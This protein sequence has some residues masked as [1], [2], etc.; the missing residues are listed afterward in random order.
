MCLLVQA[1]ICQ[2]VVWVLEAGVFTVILRSSLR[3]GAVVVLGSCIV[4]FGLAV[5]GT[6]FCV[7]WVRAVRRVHVA[8]PRRLMKLQRMVQ[9]A[10]SLNPVQVVTVL[11][12]VTALQVCVAVCI[13]DDVGDVFRAGNIPGAVA[14]P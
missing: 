14:N 9:F 1:I 11:H 7:V 8:L 5:F 4:H 13:G 3:R 2:L 10:A 12:G 6:A